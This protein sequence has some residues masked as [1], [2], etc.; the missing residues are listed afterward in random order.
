MPDDFW[1]NLKQF[2]FEKTREDSRDYRSPLMPTQFGGGFWNNL[3]IFSARSQC[4]RDRARATGDSLERETLGGFG[5]RV[6][7]LFFPAKQAPLPFEVRPVK[8]KEIWS[9]DENFAG[10]SSHRSAYMPACLALILIPFFLRMA[11]PTQAVGKDTN[12]TPMI[13]RTTFQSCPPERIKPAAV[14]ERTITL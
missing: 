3:A 1:S 9:K 5:D 7:E 14:A 4:R 11:Q 6:K 10:R 8:V 12:V 2:L 13:F